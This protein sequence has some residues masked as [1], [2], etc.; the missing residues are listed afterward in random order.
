[1]QDPYAHQMYSTEESSNKVLLR[2]KK[3]GATST[4]GVDGIEAVLVARL[5]I[6]H[7]FKGLMDFQV[8]KDHVVATHRGQHPRRECS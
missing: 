8:R 7:D 5:P 4:G 6:S 1:M 3:L 2:V